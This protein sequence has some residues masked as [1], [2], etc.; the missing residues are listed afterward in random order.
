MSRYAGWR[1]LPRREESRPFLRR[2][3]RHERRFHRAN[4]KLETTKVTKTRKIFCKDARLN[5]GYGMDIFIENPLLVEWKMMRVV[6]SSFRG[7]RCVIA[8]ER[9]QNDPPGKFAANN[10]MKASARGLA[11]HSVILGSSDL[12]ESNRGGRRVILPVE[13]VMG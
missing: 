4:R 3:V 7:G 11:M 6:Q 12:H 8:I 5:G 2:L 10:P 13:R 9:R 1:I